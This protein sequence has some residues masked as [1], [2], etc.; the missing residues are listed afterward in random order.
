MNQIKKEV[1]IM[2]KL[3]CLIFLLP[4]VAFGYYVHDVY[5]ES[6]INILETPNFHE[7]PVPAWE[8]SP[9]TFSIQSAFVVV[10]IPR[11]GQ[12]D[13]SASGQFLRSTL[14]AIPAEVT[15]RE[16]IAYITYIWEKGTLG[17][18]KISVRNANGR[19]IATKN[20]EPSIH[21]S[22]QGYAI[23]RQDSIPLHFTCPNKG[24]LRLELES[25]AD[26]PPVKIERAYLGL[27]PVPSHEG[28][29][30][31]LDFGPNCRWT[32]T[33]D[34]VGVNAKNYIHN[35]RTCSSESVPART[36]PLHEW[37]EY[38]IGKASLNRPVV[39]IVM[40]DATFIM[41]CVSFGRIYNS[42]SSPFVVALE[43]HTLSKIIASTS[44]H[45]GQPIGGTICGVMPMD[46]Y[47]TGAELRILSSTG[48]NII[49]SP[50][51]GI[52]ALNWF[53]FPLR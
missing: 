38:Y 10:R 6:E 35:P 16:C 33:G 36:T 24:S 30:G 42:A 5:R 8:A 12:W 51:Y 46:L 13:P 43:S 25:T 40:P 53:G 17:D 41:L 2:K 34:Q 9:G 29:H 22:Q 45:D 23:A 11:Y 7:Y 18:V 4:Y 39:R 52:D 27:E 28:V 37:W 20:I 31:R 21:R 15:N 47:S 48:D 26:A 50:G 19:K 1:V 32:I 3:I 49:E 44:S 14:V